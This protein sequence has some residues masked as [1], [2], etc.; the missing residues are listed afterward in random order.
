VTKR[1]QSYE[2]ARAAYRRQQQLLHRQRRR[3]ELV[4]CIEAELKQAGYRLLR[5]SPS[6][7]AYYRQAGSGRVVRVSDHPAPTPF[8]LDAEIIVPAEVAGKEEPIMQA[9]RGVVR[10]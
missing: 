5:R 7:S 10:K 2:Q 6:G 9:L 3:R 8:G 4:Q 1:R